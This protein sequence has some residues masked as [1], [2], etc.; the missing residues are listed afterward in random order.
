MMHAEPYETETGASVLF[1]RGPRLLQRLFPTCKSKETCTYNTE[2]G[3]AN[4]VFGNIEIPANL[5][6]HHQ[7]VFMP[8]S[9]SYL[10]SSRYASSSFKRY[11]VAIVVTI[12]VTLIGF[13]NCR[14][15]LPVD[16]LRMRLDEVCMLL[17][18][19][20]L[21]SSALFTSGF[22][23]KVPDKALEPVFQSL[24]NQ[25]G[26]CLRVELTKR[27]GE[28][29]GQA[30]AVTRDNYEIPITISVESAAPNRIEGLFMKPPLKMGGSI[31]EVEN[32]IKALPGMAALSVV[33]LTTNEVLSAVN[34]T[35]PL[36]IGS[37]FKLYILGYL[38][39]KIA[40]GQAKWSDVV[41]LDSLLYSLP[42]GELH[43]WPHGA[44]ITLHTLA[45]MMISKSDNTA[46]DIL[47]HKLGRSN[48]E[49]FQKQM[50]NSFA[51]MN[52]PFLSTRE[53]FRLKFAPNKELAH[54]YA[55]A[56]STARY[57]ILD[58]Q[59]H[60]VRNSTLVFDETPFLTDKIE[61]F[62]GTEDLV[63]AMKWFYQ[64]RNT[65]AGKVALGVL[66]VNRGLDVNK[67]VWRTVGYKG[68]SESGVL[69]FTY[70]L[71]HTNGTWFSVSAT[72]NDE[73]QDVDLT[74]F[75]GLVT[76]VIQLK[77]K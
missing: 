10:F 28:F 7:V 71:E 73:Q 43:T 32:D 58:N 2:L 51:S 54:E 53:M 24:I 16:P 44:P 31:E 55:K 36:A 72:W 64:A 50:G 68:G 69:N 34:T 26:P 39:H 63:A 1:H 23:S 52:I 76:K 15:Q 40:S 13:A 6:T 65:D 48:I 22:R 4:V 60:N 56:N 35:K 62:A 29:S 27:V 49:L 37:T 46:T 17:Q 74:K 5:S 30:R 20:P 3:G 77:E 70:L 18:G 25:C 59:L 19:A 67:D 12:G 21:N 8:R 41:T 66:S 45:T 11:A 9:L 38:T 75:G 57:S 42:S 47:L 33:N 14:A 61:W